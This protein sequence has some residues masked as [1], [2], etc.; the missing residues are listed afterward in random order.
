MPKT[1][2][3]RCESDGM[4]YTMVFQ[5]SL[6]KLCVRQLKHHLAD[7]TRID[8]ALQRLFYNEAEL[9]DAATCTEAGIRDNAI[10]VL[11]EWGS[12]EAP[13]GGGGGGGRRSPSFGTSRRSLS[14]ACEDEDGYSEAL[15][16]S[17]AAPATPPR[18]EAASAA[19]GGGGGGDVRRVSGAEEEDERR[20]LEACERAI[21]GEIERAKRAGGGA[22]QQAPLPPPPPP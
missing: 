22:Q 19:S 16:E 18:G 5:G 17:V 20:R 3:T 15:Y 14:R 6:R 10:L 9:H 8:P 11:R 7:L 12:A 4:V 1:I 2:K 13:A 21:D